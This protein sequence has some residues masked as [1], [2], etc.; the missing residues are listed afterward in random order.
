MLTG[1][2]ALAVTL[3]LGLVVGSAIGQAPSAGIGDSRTREGAGIGNTPASPP[4]IPDPR[5][6]HPESRSPRAVLVA[7]YEPMPPAAPGSIDVVTGKVYLDASASRSDRPIRWKWSGPYCLLMVQPNGDGPP[8]SAACAYLSGPG[9]YR[10][11]A[12]AFGVTEGQRDADAAAF[13]FIAAGTPG[14]QPSPQP[15]PVRP[16]PQPQ[17]APAP[18]RP[19]PSTSVQPAARPHA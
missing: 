14:P 5:I 9:T 13:V 11:Q 1:R 3:V 19:F 10:F 7:L 4:G 15:Q 6:P 12:V 2:K 17:P 16:Q 8:N 18:P